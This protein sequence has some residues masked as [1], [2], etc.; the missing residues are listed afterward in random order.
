MMSLLANDY[1]AG[2][3]LQQRP[4]CLSLYQPTPRHFPDKQQNPIRFR[5]LLRTLEESLRETWVEHDVRPL[6]EPFQRLADDEDFWRHRT[7]TGLTVLGSPDIFRVYTFERPVPEMAV[8]A[9]NFHLKPLLRILQSADGYHVL[10]LNRHK[11]VLFEGNRDGLEEVELPTSVQQ[12]L[13]EAV[14]GDESKQQMRAYTEKPGLPGVISGTGSK[15][16]LVDNATVR[17]FRVVDRAILEHFSRPTNFPLVLAALPEHQ[18]SF[19]KISRN[20]LLMATGIESY[21]GSL[22]AEEFRARAWQVIRPRYLARLANFVEMFGKAQ[23]REHGDHDLEQIAR[24]AVAGRVGTLLVEAERHIPGRINRESGA[25]ELGNLAHSQV[26]DLIDDVGEFVLSHGGQVVVL[27]AA[28]MPTRT[29]V[30][31]IY[32]F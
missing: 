4:P 21:P 9:N 31:A 20:S 15:S 30:A 29:G 2:I 8:V 6:L 23:A 13:D 3:L 11:A 25:I 17:F 28:R 19:R 7:L 5:N 1:A 14:G 26:D 12:K 16:D 18:A 32:R 27:P 22:P 24:S 10:G